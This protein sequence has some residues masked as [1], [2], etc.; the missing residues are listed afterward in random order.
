MYPTRVK[1]DNS[2]AA[3]AIAM[4]MSG[5][6]QLLTGR[7]GDRFPFRIVLPAPQFHGYWIVQDVAI[8]V[9]AGE[10]PPGSLGDVPQVA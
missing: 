7:L 9:I 5:Q 10:G 1:V 6:N 4:V 8:L 3:P 2:G